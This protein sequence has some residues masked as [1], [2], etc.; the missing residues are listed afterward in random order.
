[1]NTTIYGWARRLPVP[2][3]RDHFELKY[4]ALRRRPLLSELRKIPLAT[5]GVETV[6]GREVPFVEFE[7]GTHLYGRF[8]TDF[9]RRLYREWKSELPTTITEETMR[10]SIDGFLRYLYPHVMPNLTLPYTR[11]ERECLHPHHTETIEDIPGLSAEKKQ[12]LKE[13]YRPKPGESFLDVGAYMGYPTVRMSKVLGP[14]GQITS[15][16]ADPEGQWYLRQNVA[17]NGATNVKI[18]PR[19]VWNRDDET[20][21]LHKA[22]RQQNSLVTDV[23]NSAQTTPVPTTTIDTALGDRAA[24]VM[25]LTVNGAEVEAIEGMTGLVGRNRP[26]R[27]SIAGWYKR[28]N[29]RI[30]DIVAPQLRELG[31]E[32][33]ISEKGRVLAWRGA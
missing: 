26:L 20:L 31:F 33:A 29:R 7:D 27:M 11:H 23:V 21:D 6:D 13:L 14:N 3:L 12:R 5:T 16:E 32:L 8:P 2:A 19:A 30:C 10:V 25:T 1:M 22:G 9:E 24:D 17:R 28:D 18:V 15:L 4:A